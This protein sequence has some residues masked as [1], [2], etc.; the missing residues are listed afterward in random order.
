LRKEAGGLDLNEVKNMNG[1]RD[2]G[3]SDL[4]VGPQK[5]MM[6]HAWL[7]S[8]ASDPTQES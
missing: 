4:Y 5:H 6:F 3:D 7:L 2:T 8:M 1:A